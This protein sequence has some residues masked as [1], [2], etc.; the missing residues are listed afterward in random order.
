MHAGAA[1]RSA[2]PRATLC[3]RSSPPSPHFPHGATAARRQPR[4]PPTSGHDVQVARVGGA[5]VALQHQALVRANQVRKR[6]LRT[7]TRAWCVRRAW[8]GAARAWAPRVCHAP[9]TCTAHTACVAQRRPLLS[10]ARSQSQP[11]ARVCAHAQRA[12]AQTHLRTH[13]RM[14]AHTRTRTHHHGKRAVHDGIQQQVQHVRRVLGVACESARL[15]QLSPQRLG[16]RAACGRM[17]SAAPPQRSVRGRAARKGGARG[18]TAAL[19]C[20]PRCARVCTQMHGPPPPHAAA[21][22]VCTRT[23]APSC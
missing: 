15:A 21:M 9:P 4:A 13:T 14:R 20:V 5:R 18:R 17:Q 7:R 2:P 22:H 1:Q 12:A 19:P 6:L 8:R 10:Y 23:C 11:D 3:R 16:D